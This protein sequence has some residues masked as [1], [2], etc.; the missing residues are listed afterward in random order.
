MPPPDNSSR[1]GDV[2]GEAEG[3]GA[4]RVEANCAWMR[5]MNGLC[6]IL[7]RSCRMAGVGVHVGMDVDVD[8][9]VGVDVVPDEDEDEDKDKGKD[10]GED[11]VLEGA[12]EAYM[13]ML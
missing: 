1:R 8:V 12:Q 3:V 13:L 11:V 9:G 10:K 5:R 6:R 4:D 7:C 2:A